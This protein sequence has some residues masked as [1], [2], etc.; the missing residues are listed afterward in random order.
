[1][2]E[3]LQL[4]LEGLAYGGD[5]FGRGP[6][7]KMVFVPFALPGERVEVE[8]V[9]VHK[10]WARA[11]LVEVLDPSPE[12]VAAPRCP[13][14]TVCGG[15]HYQH[16]SYEKQLEAKTDILRDQLARIGGFQDP[17]VGA[18][19]GAPSPWNYRNALRF[20]VGPEGRLGFVEHGK[21]DVLP[22]TE[23]HL[24]EPAVDELWPKLDLEAV[25]GLR[26][27]SVRAGLEGESMVVL[28]AENPPEVALSSDLPTS[29]VWLSPEDSVVL[30][31]DDHF[32]IQVAGRRFRVSAGSFF[33]VQTALVDELVRLA[34][35]GLDPRP[36]ELIFDLY[37]GVG[38]FSAFLA[39]RGAQIVA[40]EES[41]WACAD[42]EVNLDEFEGVT[43]YEAPVEA[44][45]P[46]VEAAAAAVLVD[47]P[48]SGLSVEVVEELINRAP[49]RLVYVSCDPATLARDGSRL[50]AGG[51]ELQAVTPVDL[52]PQTYHIE[53][54][55][56]WRR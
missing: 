33:Q 44:A 24:P 28:Y 54:V 2:G 5:A 20:S 47:P 51:F 37:A 25:K 9:A 52:F 14:F 31:G 55:S 50:S 22:I 27:V 40:I 56:V 34:L 29:V 15:C 7:G 17:P 49:Q 48:R 19:V 41:S 13:H 8:L 53:A 11:R 18:T 21:E 35:S 38:M 6:D 26:Q 10:R 46:S 42:F 32:S 30:A 12:R 16:M 45:L 43:L 23:C 39:E 1:M 36:G 3:I 4:T